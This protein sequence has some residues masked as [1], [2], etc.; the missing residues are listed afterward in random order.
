MGFEDLAEELLP[1]GAEQLLDE[2]PLKMRPLS[3][4]SGQVS[5]VLQYFFVLPG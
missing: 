4:L 5:P 3:L 1:A 2:S